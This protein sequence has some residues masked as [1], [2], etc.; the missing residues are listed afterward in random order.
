MSQK[1]NVERC[2][3]WLYKKYRFIDPMIERCDV[4][5]IVNY[6]VL[7]KGYSEL[8]YIRRRALSAIRSQFIN[9]YTEFYVDQEILKEQSINYED[10]LLAKIDIERK[11]IPEYDESKYFV[12]VLCKNNH[13]WKPRS[14]K[15]LRY[16]GGHACVECQSADEYKIVTGIYRLGSL[17]KYG[18]DWQ[19]T[20]KSLRNKNSSACIQC[21]KINKNRHYYKNKLYSEKQNKVIDTGNMKRYI[22]KVCKKE[23]YYLNFDGSERYKSNGHCVKCSLSRSRINNEVNRNEKRKV[24]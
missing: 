7:V 3:T 18:H 13:R 15:S 5:S 22:G 9:N 21:L 1:I 19:E 23:H 11:K 10:Y 4:L 24:I 6:L 17:C 2:A 8:E 20:G 12:G 16:I 14:K